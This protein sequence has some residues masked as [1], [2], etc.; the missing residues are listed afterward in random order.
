MIFNNSVTS[1]LSLLNNEGCLMT[2]SF[3]AKSNAQAHGYKW[4]FAHALHKYKGQGWSHNT[5][6]ALAANEV[7]GRYVR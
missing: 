6:W 1:L 3:Q 5:A 7:L 2:V 4:A